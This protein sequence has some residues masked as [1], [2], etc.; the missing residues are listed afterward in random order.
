[1]T[2][3]RDTEHAANGL[4]PIFDKEKEQRRLQEAQLIGEI[5]T[6]VADIARTE[7]K[8]AGE[9]ARNDPAAL[10]AAKEKL[11]AEGKPDPSRQEIADQAYASAMKPWGTGSTVQQA[12]SAATAAVQGLAGGNI[13]QAISGAAAPYLAEV[14]HNMTTTKDA[15]GNEV[16]NTQANLMAHAVLGAVVASAQGNS[17]LAGA[18]GGALGEYIAQQIYP[19]VPRDKLTE[20]QKQTISALGTLAAGLAGGLTGGSTADAVA[21]AQAG[22]NAVENNFLNQGHPQEYADKY[23]ACNGNA[24]CEQNIRKEMAKESAENVQKLKSCWD[25]G[26]AACVADMRAK[27]ELS[28]QAYTELRKQDDMAGR[29][30]ESSAQWYADII[31]QCAGKCGWLEASL[32]KTGADGLSNIAYGALGAGS[33]PKPGQAGSANDIRFA[34]EISKDISAIGKQ[35][36][37]DFAAKNTKKSA[38]QIVV[39]NITPDEAINNLSANGYTKAMSKDGSVTIMS[40]GDTVY[41]FYP[42]STGGGIVGAESGVPSASVSVGGKIISKIRF[43]GEK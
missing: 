2:L 9:K 28:D 5:G 38:G 33:V 3:S 19:G 29:A 43:P 41:R 8:I 36:D 34:N 10:K 6:Q 42:F 16:V 18:S 12:I 13:G 24:G 30:Y 26:D 14:I 11:V 15:N 22:K 1:S 40:K 32:L 27:M 37:I 17:A 25:S 20:E 35:T 31:D 7:G 23:K 21:G 4:S 39:K